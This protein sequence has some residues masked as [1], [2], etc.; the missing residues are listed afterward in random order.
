VDGILSISPEALPD[1][2]V[3]TKEV[4]RKEEEIEGQMASGKSVFEILGL[5]RLV[6]K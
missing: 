3:L 4:A 6:P 1:A 2:L 5:T